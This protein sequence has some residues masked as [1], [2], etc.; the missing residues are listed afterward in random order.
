MPRKYLLWL[1]LTFVL[2]TLTA[3]I[4]LFGARLGHEVVLENTGT[5]TCSTECINRGQCGETE[6][7]TRYILGGLDSPKVDNHNRA[8]PEDTAVLIQGNRTENAI[9]NTD[10]Q[11]F[12]L[13]FYQITTEGLMPK[14]GWVAGWCIASR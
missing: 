5:L 7:G 14:N 13:T 8:F 11:P 6:D 1:T 4:S 9:T 3:C 10:G 12:S 2:L